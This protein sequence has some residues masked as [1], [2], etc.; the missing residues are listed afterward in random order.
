[1]TNTLTNNRPRASTGR[2]RRNEGPPLRLSQRPTQK[3]PRPG[4]S[5]ERESIAAPAPLHA[6]NA[7]TRHAPRALL[8]CLALLFT[9][10]VL[11]RGER[12]RS[13]DADWKFLRAD[14]PGAERPDFDDSDWRALDV[15]HDWSIEDL[16][17]A[18]KTIVSCAVVEG[19]WRF[20]KGDDSAW[21]NPVL[22]DSEWQE[23]QLPDDW[24]RH[25]N[26]TEDNAYGWFRRHVQLPGPAEAKTL[27]LLLGKIQDVDETYLN[28][29]R[30]GG[31]GSFPPSFKTASD[32]ERCY[33]VPPHLVHGDGTD[34]V[35]VRVFHATGKGGIYEAGSSVGRAGPF[36]PAASPGGSSTGHVLGGTGWYRK[37]FRLE[38]DDAGKTVSV[39][40]DGVYMDAEVW[41][42][43][44]S[45]GSHPYGYTS[46]AYDLT[47]HLNP[48]GQENLLAVRVRNEGKNSRWY[49]GSGIYRHVWL[50]VT[51]PLHVALW[52]IQVTTPQVSGKT[53]IVKIATTIE[54]SGSAGDIL[55]RTR[56]I[57]PNGKIVKSA[58]SSARSTGATNTVLD[59]VIE[60]PSPQLWSVETPRLYGAE[61]E[62]V[63]GGAV[64]DRSHAAFGIRGIEVDAE[65]GLRL[66]GQPIK[67][68]GG[69]VHHDN[70]PLGSAAIDRAEERRVE[71]LKA[72]GFN[73]IRT[74]HNPP[75]PAF[76]DACDRLGMLVID[77]AFDQWEEGKNPQ[78]YHRFFKEWGGRD[79]AA[80]VR[81][82]RN[83]PSV[84]L[85]SIGNEIH[86]RFSRPDLAEYLR[87][88]VLAQD[89]TRPIT[90][91]ICDAWDWP[92][93]D[94][95]KMSDPAFQ[96]LDVG[97]YNYLPDK[98]ESDHA[99]NPRRVMV[100]TESFPVDAFRC[101]DM[102]EKHPYAIGDFV[103][104]ALDYLGEAGIGHTVL[105]NEKN[106]QLMPW[107]WFNAWCGDM[108]LCGFKKPQS[109]YRDVV[110][111]R[112]RIELAV[113]TPLPPGRS[114]K[115][116]LWGWPDELQSW[117]WPV[118]KDTPMQVAV[119]ST[120]EKVRLELNGKKLGEKLVSAGT[121]LTARFEV[122]Y[123]P[124]TLRAVGLING[125]EVAAVAIHSAGPPKKLRLTVDRPDIRASRNDL[126]YVTVEAVDAAGERV[127]YA[128]VPVQFTVSGA[129]ELAAVGSGNPCD[130]ASFRQPEHTTFQGRCLAILRP[131]GEPGKITL[132]AESEKLSPATVTV[133][134][135]GR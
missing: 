44:K 64:R 78:D 76:L 45:L 28:G 130:P 36:D 77:E 24:R 97:G 117:S 131:V 105:D 75:S 90:A 110:W 14:A 82:D 122:P 96:H 8:A 27:E 115:L 61:V 102:V 39:R 106:P 48:A 12:D 67:L 80:M 72:N 88:A 135:G 133:R 16:P 49:S 93:F 100:C 114:E 91:A 123:A 95:D 121:K 10:T 62:L 9:F 60:L 54:D 74:S 58:Q 33:R 37:H 13:L 15:P 30:I 86:E 5:E 99:R 1:M 35:A 32:Q 111:G 19:K 79:V 56:L 4:W 84:I 127:P 126:A 22:N 43:G 52:G 63:A 116:S 94:W 57:G 47:P 134:C 85:W 65:R 81:R 6:R 25:S 7:P 113:H 87:Q 42:N 17:S 108:D 66:N 38:P 21:K 103:W 3:S 55:V 46:F 29:T 50:T 128:A 125:A 101:W 120:C 34:V 98:Y 41:V 119:Y 11:A 26:Y 92:H 112:S 109:F 71:I 59:Q 40:F 104:T 31:M 73:A 23:V 53:A 132:K 118:D 69:C 89:A 68:K 18:D 20:H 124:G 129:G 70:G 107:P 51:D 2:A 83:H